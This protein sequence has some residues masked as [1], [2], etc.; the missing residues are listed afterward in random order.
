MRPT[1]SCPDLEILMPKHPP[2]TK[3]VRV[4]TPPAENPGNSSIRQHAKTFLTFSRTRG[5][6]SQCG[7]SLGIKESETAQHPKVPTRPRHLD[8]ETTP[9]A[10]RLA[11]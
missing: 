8:L 4:G 10:T 7:E 3:Q 5:A 1:L 9:N 11:L 6:H 2:W